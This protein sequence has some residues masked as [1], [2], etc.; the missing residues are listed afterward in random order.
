MLLSRRCLSDERLIR[1]SRRDPARFGDLVER[2]HDGVHR[3][4]HR[5]A[6]RDL[7]DDLAAE[8]F[9]RAFQVRMRYEAQ[10]DSALPWLY[11]IATNLLRAHRRTEDR[12]LRAFVSLGVD[13]AVA[14]DADRVIDRVDAQ[15]RGVELAAVLLALPEGQRDAVCLRALAD[16]SY[17][18]IA[19]AMNTTEESVRGLLR[20]GT[21]SARAE[22]AATGEDHR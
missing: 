7:A 5:R 15:R 16:L 14:F 4:L 9:A 1:Q 18:E 19:V 3:Y 11:G 21:A 17:G 8:T 13:S 12:G 6:G 10:T 22:L 2:H 20:R